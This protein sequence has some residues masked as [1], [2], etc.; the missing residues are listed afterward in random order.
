MSR[1]Q[2]QIFDE[3]AHDH[4]ATVNVIREAATSR[5]YGYGHHEINDLNRLADRLEDCCRIPHIYIHPETAHIKL[6]I[7][8]CKSRLCVLCGARRAKELHTQILPLV[9][10]MNSPRIIVLTPKSTDRPLREQIQTLVKNFT[11]LRKTDDWKRR[12]SAGFYCIEVTH[13]DV[14]NQWHPHLHIIV[15]GSYWFWEELRNTWHDVTGNSFIIT[16]NRCNSHD[17]AVREITK[18][19]TKTQNIK[20]VPPYRVPEWALQVKSMRFINMFGGLRK[21]K[22]EKTDTDPYEGYIYLAALSAVEATIA[23]GKPGAQDVFNRILIQNA[24]GGITT[25]GPTESAAKTRRFKLLADLNAL[26]GDDPPKPFTPLQT[27]PEDDLLF[28][29]S[30]VW[31]N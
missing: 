4:Q 24:R 3:I 29:T 23:Q 7:F 15:D 19:S 28:D 26:L 25:S 21:P 16:I 22:Q 14:T 31:D 30:P 27:E 18:Y 17:H 6:Q 13:N 5:R 1:F 12:F 8:R 10:N 2:N 9:K 11:K 20:T